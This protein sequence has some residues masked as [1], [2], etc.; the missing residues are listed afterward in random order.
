MIIIVYL[1]FCIGVLIGIACIIIFLSSPSKEKEAAKTTAI[2]IRGKTEME[3]Y[4]YD[5]LDLPATLSE[6]YIER[7]W[8]E[9]QS[10]TNML[11]KWWTALEVKFHTK[12]QIKFIEAQREKLEAVGRFARAKAETYRAGTD[13]RNA[14]TDF[15]VAG[16][17]EYQNL[18]AKREIS[19]VKADVAE[20]EVRI[21]EAV[22]RKVAARE[23]RQ[24]G[25]ETKK[26]KITREKWREKMVADLNTVIDD[27]LAFQGAITDK[28]RDLDK[29]R[30]TWEE[31]ILNDTRLSQ[32]ES[33][34]QLRDIEAVYINLRNK[35]LTAKPRG[36]T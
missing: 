4:G 32:E 34:R 9:L 8:R 20:N 1:L 28:L 19:G 18:R 25:E 29:K 21:A 12:Q 31:E 3:K 26:P 23:R 30:R 24:T 13:A 2:V 36:R 15:H 11:N 16:K 35:I 22:R 33:E 27:E 6:E 10:D 7:R 5:N 17:P 14:E